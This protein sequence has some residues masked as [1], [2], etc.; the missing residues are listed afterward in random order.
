MGQT[1][2]GQFEFSSWTLH[3]ASIILFAT[4]WGLVLKEW[5]GTSVKTKAMVTAGVFLL[6]G[7]TVVVGYGN[8]LKTTEPAQSSVT[9]AR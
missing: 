5:R 4:L 2:M 3:M 8:Y 7:A 9:V 6:I 1:K